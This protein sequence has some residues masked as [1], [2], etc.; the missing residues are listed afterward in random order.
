M[1]VGQE[2]GRAVAPAPLSSHPPALL[3]IMPRSTWR[4]CRRRPSRSLAACCA[5][6]SSTATI[7]RSTSSTPGARGPAWPTGSLLPPSAQLAQPPR[8]SGVTPTPSVARPSSRSLHAIPL[9][10]GPGGQLA[11]SGWAPGE[12]RALGCHANRP[13]RVRSRVGPSL[14]AVPITGF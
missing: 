11:A 4:S 2:P 14:G 10:V 6:P 9:L 3:Q 8:P 1:R 13:E 7:T 12:E 5:S